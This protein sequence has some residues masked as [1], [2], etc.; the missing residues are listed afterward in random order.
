M[1]VRFL[2]KR[3]AVLA[4]AAATFGFIADG[5]SPVVPLGILLGGFLA[6]YKTRLNTAAIANAARGGGAA[7]GG[8]VQLL[9]Q[10][11][12]LGVLAVTAFASLRLFAGVAAGLLLLPLFICVNAATEWLGLTHNAWG[13]APGGAKGGG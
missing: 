1:L 5:L 12:L 2:A 10:M 8:A 6:V 9:F 4:V 7:R 11:L 3:M 13:E